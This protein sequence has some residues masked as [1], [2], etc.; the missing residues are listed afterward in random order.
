MTLIDGTFTGWS[1]PCILSIYYDGDADTIQYFI[2]GTYAATY[3][4]SGLANDERY[5]TVDGSAGSAAFNFGQQPFVN[6]VLPG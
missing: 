5:L 2:D 1:N 4:I 3:E 6:S